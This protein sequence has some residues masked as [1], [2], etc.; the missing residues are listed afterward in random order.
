VIL[1]EISRSASADA[2]T[3][4]DDILRLN[5]ARH[6]DAIALIDPPNRETFTNDA[7]R[8]F[9]YAQADRAVSG[10]AMRLRD[11]G[12][13][14]D[15]VVAT[16]FANTSESILTLLG[17]MRAG[18]IAAP[19]PLL[20]RRTECIAALSRI[21]TKALITCMRV[22]DADHGALA[23]QV[24]A[25]I[26]T[27]RHV[28]GFGAPLPEGFIS[29]DDLIDET[30]A[31]PPS[32]FV[33]TGRDNP[34]LHVAVITFDMTA[35][36][37]VP[38]ARNHVEL[39]AGG[40][41]IL[42]ESRLAPE[43]RILSSLP[44]ASFAGIALT[45]VPWLLSAGPLNLHQP[46]DAATL[47]SQLQGARC[48]VAILPGPLVAQLA[49]AELFAEPHAPK[50]ILA[51]WRAP[52]RLPFSASMLSL[53]STLIDVPLF[54]EIGLCA[55]R[56]TAGRPAYIPAG[57]LR[58]PQGAPGAVVVASIVRMPAGTL[59]FGGP[60]APHHPFP[61]AAG[62]AGSY[63]KT[64]DDGTL[65]TGFPCRSEK[66][67]GELVVTGPVAGL[68]SIGGYRFAMR[69]V[70][71]AVLQADKE[72]NVVA[73]PDTLAGHRLAG[74]SKDRSAVRHTLNAVGL[75]PLIVRAFRDR[76]GTPSAA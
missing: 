33:P 75:N 35:D 36:G 74:H 67:T 30:A 31:N 44:A 6:P 51:F 42:A 58:A 20:W 26:F 27:I 9:T 19:M 16:Q 37:I 73:L 5:A 72:A 59:G 25:E 17:I 71:Q 39:L 60:M 50:N 10:I 64:G 65:D 62:S 12:L 49:E 15:S 43:S 52:E 54:G 38:V 76:S 8:C 1:G 70:Q 40:L 55:L 45:L 22:G 7:P 66:E 53:D 61:H 18:M 29:F 28:G 24:A 63:F 46:F 11:I 47:S 41:S 13:S 4:L 3:R 14:A 2:G 34:A 48:D 57:K 69:D 56:R 21:G 32:S 23:M 68:F